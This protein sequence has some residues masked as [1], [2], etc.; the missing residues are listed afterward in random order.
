MGREYFID[1]LFLEKF[2][3]LNHDFIGIQ[4]YFGDQKYLDSWL[5]QNLRRMDYETLIPL[6]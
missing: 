3:M 6:K 4:T 2:S 1:C 5:Q